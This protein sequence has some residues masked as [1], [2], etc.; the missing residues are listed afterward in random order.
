[1][2]H[3][4]VVSALSHNISIRNLPNP[5]QVLITGYNA[6]ICANINN[7]TAFDSLKLAKMF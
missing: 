7:T 5:T 4:E 2:C 6:T 3:D 1:M